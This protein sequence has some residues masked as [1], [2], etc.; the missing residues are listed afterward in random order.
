MKRTHI[1][2]PKPKSSFLL[3]ACPNCGK[4]V[5][6]YSHTTT[7]I[8]CKTCKTSI[9]EKTGSRAMLRNKE[10]KKLD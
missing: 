7:D 2:I 9:A 6:V 8:K 1:P 5:V 10:Y 3:I 4:E